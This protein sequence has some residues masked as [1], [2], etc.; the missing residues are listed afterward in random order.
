MY[1]RRTVAAVFSSV[2]LVSVAAAAPFGASPQWVSGQA[3][4]AE[5]GTVPTWA[6]AGNGKVKR[7]AARLTASKTKKAAYEPNTVLVRL[8]PGASAADRARIASKVGGKVAGT[9]GSTG[10][11]KITT[12]SAARDA[13]KVLQGDP[14]VVTTALD[15]RRYPTKAPN[16]WLYPT[17]Q[18]YLSTIRMPQAW[19]LQSSAT[20]VTVAVV[21][22][23]VDS[24][25]RD[26]VGRVVGGYNSVSN[27]TDTMDT[28]GHG[29]MVSG[30][31]AANTGN[32][33]GIAGVT[34]N[35]RIMPIKVFAGEYAFDSDIAEGVTWAVDHGAKVV[36]MSLGGPGENPMLHE[37][38]KYAV[39]KGV[40]VV[41]AAGN[42]G[43][44]E[45]Q[46]PAYYPEVL[47][48]GATD[49]GGNLTDFSSWGDHVDVAAP[50]FGILSTYPVDPACDI[51][52]YA[53][54][55]GTSFSAPLVAGVAALVKAKNPTFTP[56][57][58][59]ERIKTTARDAGP[60]GV[61]PY[62][63]FGVLDAYRALGGAATTA[64]PQRAGG[65]GEPNDTPA[66]AAALTATPVSAIV[67]MEGDTDWYR[68][69]L[70]TDR[71]VTLS[72]TPP[73]YDGLWAQ[74]LDPI[75]D[76]YDKDLRLI[77]HVDS[78]DPAAVE[79]F[80]GLLA[81]GAYY[82]QVRNYNGAAD[83]RP[84]DLRMSTSAAEI[85]PFTGERY[86]PQGQ[87]WA[88]TVAIGDVTGDGRNDVLMATDHEEGEGTS[89]YRMYVYAQQPDGTLDSG[90]KY[91][92]IQPAS[93]LAMAVLDATGDGRNDVAVATTA[94]VAVYAQ[95]GSGKLGAPVLIPGTAN[96][97]FYSYLTAADV[98][99]DGDKD[100]LFSAGGLYLLTQEPAGVFTVSTIATGP[101]MG[102]V[103]AGDVNGDGR[104][105]V[106]TYSGLN[107]DGFLTISL[108]GA[109][110]WTTTARPIP[111]GSTSN[112][113]E[114]ADVT[115][116]GL[117]DVVYTIES[118]FTKPGGNS[119]NLLK[120]LPDGTLAD[121]Q[122]LTSPGFPGGVTV[123]DYDKDGR[124]DLFV[125]NNTGP[126][127]MYLQQAGGSFAAPVNISV[128]LTQHPN[129]RGMAVGD[130]N[131]D[132]WVDLVTAGNYAL[133]LYVKYNV[134][135]SVPSNAPYA[136]IR[137]TSVADFATNLDPVGS[138]TV[139][140]VRALNPATVNTKTVKLYDGRTGQVVPV[141]VGYNVATR[142]ITIAPTGPATGVQRKPMFTDGVPYRLVVGGVQDTSGNIHEGYSLSFVG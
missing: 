129:P 89:G 60:R 71:S 82:A 53:Y 115:G 37:A 51:D 108:N 98:D 72:V 95:N 80:T 73:R 131:G 23:G 21:D 63:G 56:T 126:V 41:V 16:D 137:Q 74:N 94:G 121:A 46:Y 47:A 100:L 19:D 130:V 31:I 109:D 54:G 59:I 117:A 29:T 32:G 141:K 124:T 122:Q 42:E 85:G 97:S 88:E 65:T 55:D 105:D 43:T 107:L 69:D 66:R 68:F 57:Q 13:L 77:A 123:A 99:G 79:Q 132:G 116:D 110:G 75:L 142:T 33:E 35:G 92:E 61:D 76:V 113:V 119:V 11:L 135:G 84:Y 86:L 133:G 62:Y 118:Q 128:S 101:Y 3:A 70:A 34:W 2:L 83:T 48:V 6:P 25:N 127:F 36:N 104:V 12:K 111:H 140:T 112:G 8:R 64:F 30:I 136:W 103:A 114:I 27:N 28:A 138:M 44:D 26:L 40:V 78:T 52:C 49:S 102:E 67:A 81:V 1:I 93:Q 4:A 134:R 9:V 7:L 87:A 14:A 139:T 39:G 90:T 106:V 38:I 58:V 125:A 5:A 10:Y 15:Q 17:D 45:P 18:G 120:Q 22:T 50:G 20:A 96:T 24:R 91:D